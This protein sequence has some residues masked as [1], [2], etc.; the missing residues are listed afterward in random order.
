MTLTPLHEQ[1]VGRVRLALLVLLGAVAFMLMIACANVANLL[2]ARAVTRRKEIAIRAALGAGRGRLARQLMTESILLSALGGGLGLLLAWWGVEALIALAPDDLPRVREIAIDKWV[3]AFST[4]A[5][6]LTGI[7]FGLA[8]ALMV[9][10]VDFQEA[11]KEGGK[12]SAAS[13]GPRLRYVLVVGEV[14]LSLTLLIGAGLMIRSFVRLMAVHPGFT[15][16]N[17]LT[18]QIPLPRSKY[19]TPV[20]QSA[21]YQQVI[22]RVETLEGVVAVGG[23]SALPMS[24]EDPRAAFVAEGWTPEDASKATNV[25]YRLISAKLLSHVRYPVA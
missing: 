12:S 6:L 25:Y 3:L 23:V 2:M 22:E 15:A 17:V 18:V 19:S 9:S 13:V 7:I 8:P 5:S 20:Q 4:G 14:A 24:G 10:R 11:L 16:D 21:F 1:V